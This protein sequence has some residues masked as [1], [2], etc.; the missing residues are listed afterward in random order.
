MKNEDLRSFVAT[1]LC[2]DLKHVDEAPDEVCKLAKLGSDLKHD[3][4]G[5]DKVAS[6]SNLVLT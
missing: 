3:D 2:S 5:P 6:W 1:L 4:K